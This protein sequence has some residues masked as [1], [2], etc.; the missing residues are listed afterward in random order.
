[1]KF[2]EEPSDNL[3]PRHQ[4]TQAINL[5]NPHVW[6]KCVPCPINLYLLHSLLT[7]FEEVAEWKFV[8]F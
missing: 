4:I 1:M 2:A 8:Q 7:F 5:N 6:K 3:T